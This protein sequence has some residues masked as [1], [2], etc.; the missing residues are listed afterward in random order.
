MAKRISLLL[1]L[2]FILVFLV[3]GY[4]Q[5]TEQKND[6]LKKIDGVHFEFDETV[7]GD[8]GILEPMI[9]SYSDATMVTIPLRID[10]G[11]N[12]EVFLEKVVFKSYIVGN[13]LEERIVEDFNIPSKGSRALILDDVKISGEKFD[14]I[15][16]GANADVEAPE[17][18]TLELAVEVYIFYP[19]ELGPLRIDRF[20]IPHVRLEGDIHIRSIMGGRTKEEAAVEFF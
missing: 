11:Q 15:L 16:L 3:I 12:E 20:S 18:A 4:F 17:D 2:L 5:Y 19:L 6:F 14:N 10:N 13:L 7:L 1:P 8:S 9:K